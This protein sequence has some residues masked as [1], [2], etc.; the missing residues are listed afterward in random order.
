[1]S[2]ANTL[3]TTH[4]DR[5]LARRLE[6]DPEFRTEFERQRREIDQVPSIVRRPNDR[7]GREALQRG[8]GGTGT[9]S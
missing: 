5:R 1:M 6:E 8:F 4:H 9:P 7:C 3:D 2:P